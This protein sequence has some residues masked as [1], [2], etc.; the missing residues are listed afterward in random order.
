METWKIMWGNIKRGALSWP[1]KV[2][3]GFA[4]VCLV[5]AL[6]AQLMMVI[7]DPAEGVRETV[8]Q[9]RILAPVL[10]GTAVSAV[11]WLSLVWLVKETRARKLRK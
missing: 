9:W 2:S 1:A 5:V 6:V 7:D 11:A 4:G 3:F 8:R 10:A